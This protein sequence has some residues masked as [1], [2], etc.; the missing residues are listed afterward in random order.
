MRTIGASRRRAYNAGMARRKILVV[1][2]NNSFVELCIIILEGAGFEVTGA[3]SGPQALDM[4]QKELPDLILLDLMMPGMSGIEVCQKVRAEHNGDVRIVI[5]TADGREA[6][7]E[8]SLAAG[9][10]GVLNKDV[11]IYD[12][13]SR[14]AHFLHT[15]EPLR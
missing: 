14:L 10:D 12:I 2:D 15:T 1:D 13:P 7:H 5:Y 6:T 4:L 11:P 9:A 8:R 3:F